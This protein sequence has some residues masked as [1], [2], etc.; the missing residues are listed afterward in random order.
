M[1][2][3]SSS[4]LGDIINNHESTGQVAKWGLELMDLN[5]T[6]APRTTIKSQVLTD[7]MAEQI[8]EQTSTVP[9]KVE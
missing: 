4:G 1:V 5:I 8:E 9:T 7:F 3:L 6:Y 2:V